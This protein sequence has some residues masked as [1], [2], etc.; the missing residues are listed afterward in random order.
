V[1]GWIRTIFTALHLLILFF[2][3]E[4]AIEALDRDHVCTEYWNSRPNAQQ[5]PVTA[6][7]APNENSLATSISALEMLLKKANQEE[8][9]A[10][11]SILSNEIPKQEALLLI[12]KQIER[13][14]S[15]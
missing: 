9:Q 2:L 8:V 13:F 12:N 5:I 15:Q 10:L 11:Q 1:F 4:Q 7:V 6:P 14:Q 3:F